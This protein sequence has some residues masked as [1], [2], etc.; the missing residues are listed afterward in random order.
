MREW[1]E[2]K[3]LGTLLEEAARRWGP[4]EALYYEGRHWSFAH[5]QADIDDTA[6]V[7]ICLGILPGDHVALWMSNRPEWLSTFFAL[8]KIGAVVVPINTRFRTSDLAYVFRRRQDD[9]FLQLQPLL[10]PCGI[11]KFSPDGWG[12]YKRHLEA[13]QHQV[14]KEHTQNIERTHIN[15]RT[16]IKRFVRRT[17]GF[18]KTERMHDLVLGLFINRYEFGQAL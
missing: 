2:K 7:L 9:V 1:F 10:E 16:R 13:E 11:T 8:A 17:L 5:L 6:R 15:L 4:R 12:A 3:T 14:G 18:S